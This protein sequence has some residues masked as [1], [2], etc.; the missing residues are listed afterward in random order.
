MNISEAK[1]IAVKSVAREY[2]EN[3]LFVDK[4]ETIQRFKNLIK[5]IFSF[6]IEVEEQPPIPFIS[7]NTY[8][9]ILKFVDN[10]QT[11]IIEI[12]VTTANKIHII[13]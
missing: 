12:S 2:F 10:N 11:R 13:D 7:L 3:T 8:Y 9:Y 4:K 6:D 5:E 1:I